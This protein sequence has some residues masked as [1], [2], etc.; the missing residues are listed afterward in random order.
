[1]NS[2][3]ESRIA[4]A[5]TRSTDPDTS[6]E[7][8]ASV[9]DRLTD[10]QRMVYDFIRERGTAIDSDIV[11]WGFLHGYAESTL[12]RRRTELAQMGLLEVCGRRK[13]KRNRREL[14]W[15]VTP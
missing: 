12:R 9:M 15:Q 1:M 8:A 11:A 7:A 6:R 13:N 5:L 3:A 2:N 10:L 4:S 14:V